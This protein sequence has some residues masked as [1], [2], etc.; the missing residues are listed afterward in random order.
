[1]KSCCLEIKGGGKQK[2]GEKVGG[3]ESAVTPFH[4]VHSEGESFRMPWSKEDRNVPT[5]LP[6]CLLLIPSTRAA[7]ELYPAPEMRFYYSV[8]LYTAA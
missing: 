6:P 4:R 8:E 7:P 2:R 5:V 1:M 3:G